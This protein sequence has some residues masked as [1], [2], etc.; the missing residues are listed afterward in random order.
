MGYILFSSPSGKR[1]FEIISLNCTQL[2]FVSG[3]ILALPLNMIF[4]YGLHPVMYQPKVPYMH[5]ASNHP[6]KIV[7]KASPQTSFFEIQTYKFVLLSCDRE[8]F[9]VAHFMSDNRLLIIITSCVM[10]C[11]H[12]YLEEHFQTHFSLWNCSTNSPIPS[13]STTQSWC[14]YHCEYLQDKAMQEA[15]HTAWCHQDL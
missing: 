8:L 6:S 13:L 7:W 1:G 5:V 9:D 14:P 4:S 12:E 10:V 15:Y 11:I 3:F 2:C